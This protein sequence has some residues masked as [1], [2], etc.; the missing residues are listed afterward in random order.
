[1]TNS[2]LYEKLT[3]ADDL[4][5]AL[6]EHFAYLADTD[7]FMP[8]LENIM[9]KAKSV[10]LS[11]N[12]LVI[13]F[14]GGNEMSC[15]EP[16]EDGYE[17]YPESF[18]KIVEKH[19]FISFP[20]DGGWALELGESGNFEPEMFED[21][22]S[23]LTEQ[24]DNL[25]DI[26]CPFTD[27]SDWWIYHPTEKNPQSEPT[28]CLASH[29]SADIEKTVTCNIGSLFLKR[30]AECLDLNDI[31]PD[32]E[33]EITFKNDEDDE[34]ENINVY[35]ILS[36]PTEARDIPAFIA[37]LETLSTADKFSPQAYDDLLTYTH[38]I[39]AKCAKDEIDA[40]PV[41]ETV[42]R[43]FP[44]AKAKKPREHLNYYA[45]SFIYA[46]REHRDYYPQVKARYFD[47]PVDK[48]NADSLYYA[49]I[50]LAR[51]RWID[52]ASEVLKRIEESGVVYLY[53]VFEDGFYDD[54]DEPR[55]SEFD[56][57]RERMK[58]RYYDKQESK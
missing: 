9:A 13:H 4:Q 24:V 26:L 2:E 11:E 18:R 23:D 54:F 30:I 45:R 1:M 47:A 52:E 48:D 39:I 31:V 58:K 33:V 35:G 19:E 6:V 57:F 44:E 22:D 28:L 34:D 27:Y 41:F 12:N 37:G 14:P 40:F 7:E 43:L 56:G 50:Q 3:T 8:V 15:N 5:K 29:E 46:I 16:A 32:V 36:K 49:A 55:K 20:D 21:G 51:M 17:K 10:K 42:L 25:G 38:N 53:P